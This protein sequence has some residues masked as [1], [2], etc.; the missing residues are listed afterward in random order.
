MS[1]FDGLSLKMMQEEGYK[2]VIEVKKLY[3]DAIIPTK[4]TDGSVGY[5]L[6][7]QEHVVVDYGGDAVV[8]TGIAFNF[9][10][11]TFRKFYGLVYLR[12]SAYSKYNVRLANQVGVIDTDYQGEIKL[13]LESIETPDEDQIMHGPYRFQIPKGTRLAQI[14]IMEHPLYSMHEVDEFDNSTDRGDGGFGSTG[15]GP[16]LGN[17]TFVNIPLKE[18]TND[19]SLRPRRPASD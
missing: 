13:H 14:V 3:E 16:N 5:D 6:Y 10:K 17:A 1:W 11:N 15:Q 12:S 18:E 9:S 8:G 19:E 7:L 2:A 4:A